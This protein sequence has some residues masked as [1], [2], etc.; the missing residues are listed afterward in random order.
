MRSMRLFTVAL[1]ALLLVAVACGGDE[2]SDDSGSE[3]QE[4]ACE[5]VETVTVEESDNYH[6]EGTFAADDYSTSPPAGGVHAL[7]FLS[8]GEIYPEPQAIGDAVHSLD[9]GAVIVWTNGVEEDVRTEI[10][11]WHKENVATDP[12]K[13]G[14]K[15]TAIIVVENPDMET[16]IAFSAWGALQRCNEWDSAAAD[17]FLE[18]YYASGPEG[19][20]ACGGLLGDPVDVP[21]CNEL[22][23]GG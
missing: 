10:E 14:T 1:L 2:G 21:R 3:E 13:P 5:E 15:Y 7:G 20:V 22:T 11:S 16:P 18:Q 23:S 6:Q 9:H 12:F 19:T 4:A 17:A 8:E